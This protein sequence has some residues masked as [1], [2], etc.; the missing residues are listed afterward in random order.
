MQIFSIFTGGEASTP[1]EYP[2]YL[3]VAD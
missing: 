1:A 3:C 2:W